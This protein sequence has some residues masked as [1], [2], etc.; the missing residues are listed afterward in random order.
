[1]HDTPD[2]C[3]QSI[4]NVENGFQ[5]HGANVQMRTY[6]PHGNEWDIDNHEEKSS[7]RDMAAPSLC[8]ATLARIQ[9]HT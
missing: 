5:K 3:N 1:M 4:D 8:R 6:I 9:R 2:A 7:K